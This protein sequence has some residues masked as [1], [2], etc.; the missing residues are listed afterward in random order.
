MVWGLHKR[1]LRILTS[2][3]DDHILGRDDQSSVD[4]RRHF[5]G[6]QAAVRPARTL[7]VKKRTN[8]FDIFINDPPAVSV[9]G[10][11]SDSRQSS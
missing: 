7:P 4:V 10:V 11:N 9:Q 6:I 3:W 5:A 2:D 1:V 8:Y